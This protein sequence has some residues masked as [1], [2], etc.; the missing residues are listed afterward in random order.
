[1]AMTKH[2]QIDCDNCLE[3]DYCTTVGSFS[4]AR[5]MFKLTGWLFTNRGE[6][7]SKKCKQ[8]FKDKHG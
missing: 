2:V 6:F 7:C 4:L 5:K 3:V 1:M 8:K